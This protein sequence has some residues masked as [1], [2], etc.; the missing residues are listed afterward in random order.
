MNFTE[1][2]GPLI[3]RHTR[4]EAGLR[5]GGGHDAVAVPRGGI[6]AQVL[7]TAC[8]LLNGPGLVDRSLCV[9]EPCGTM[10]LVEK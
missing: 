6:N 1:P 8:R 9:S 10:H 5:I 2:S 4:A 7:G 3:S